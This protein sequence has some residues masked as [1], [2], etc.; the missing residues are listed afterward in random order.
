M[1]NKQLTGKPEAEH[2]MNTLER[3]NGNTV[4]LTVEKQRLNTEDKGE[5]AHKDVKYKKR[6]RSEK[7]RKG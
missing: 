5:K 3:Y 2:S 1:V 7:K 6:I 4:Y